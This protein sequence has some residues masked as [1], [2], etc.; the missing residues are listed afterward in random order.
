MDS[1][2]SASLADRVANSIKQLS[3]AAQD[4]NTVSGEMGQAIAA[5]DTVL[6]SLNIGVPTWTRIGGGSD[7]DGLGYWSR[8]LGYTKITNKWGI[9]L[10]DVSGD[11][12]YPEDEHC[13]SWLFNDAPRWLRI[14]GVAKIPDLIEALIKNTLET[15]KRIKTKTAEVNELA[16][17]IAQAARN[18]KGKTPAAHAV[19]SPIAS[20][21][22]QS[23]AS[24][25]DALPIP[26]SLDPV[27]VASPLEGSGIPLPSFDT[28][29][30]ESKSAPLPMSS[31]T[32]ISFTVSPPG[33]TKKPKGGK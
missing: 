21:R 9:A 5:I 2:T 32:G 4:L 17:V 30:V 16:T 19:A 24:P 15:T 3:S 18:E 13:D 8:D 10:R 33:G 31:V 14:E 20:P 26:S 28:P 29:K 23:V 11:N 22:P 1:P 6:Q 12:R 7:E 25:L 27:P